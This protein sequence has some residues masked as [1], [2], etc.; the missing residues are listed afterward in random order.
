MKTSHVLVAAIAAAALACL[1]P[2]A[3][4]AAPRAACGLFSLAEIRAVLAEP[5]VSM[6]AGTPAP[7][8]RGDATLST[9]TYALPK[10]FKDGSSFTLMWAPAA[11]LAQTAKF[12]AQRKATT[13]MKNNVLVLATVTKTS[14]GTAVIDQVASK[15]LLAAILAKL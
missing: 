5:V 11:E 7:T 1:A 4:N 6:I 12:Y 8:V 3:A 14:G 2:A 10:T 9:C 13:Q 15:K